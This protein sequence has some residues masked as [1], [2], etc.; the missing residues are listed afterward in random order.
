MAGLTAAFHLAQL[1]MRLIG[2]RGVDRV[3][4][5]ARAIAR[6]ANCVLARVGMPGSVRASDIS[7][8]D[9][10]RFTVATSRSI[11]PRRGFARGSKVHY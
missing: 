9:S 6:L 4:C 5:H 3:V 11:A 8:V 1:D 10:P 7:L 2:V